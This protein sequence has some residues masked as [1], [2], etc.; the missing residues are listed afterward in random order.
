MQ[1]CYAG[2]VGVRLVGLILL[3]ILTAACE[4]PPR[5]ARPTPLSAGQPPIYPGAQNVKDV[6]EGSNDSASLKTITFETSDAADK[7]LTYYRST[8]AARVGSHE[9]WTISGLI[10]C[11]TYGRTGASMNSR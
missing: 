4:A 1:I 8:L 3:L 5:P 7:V 9:R 2:R 10:G 6:F 11:T